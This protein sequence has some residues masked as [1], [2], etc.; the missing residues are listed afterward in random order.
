[1]KEKHTDT[2]VLLKEKCDVNWTPRSCDLIPFDFFRCG[3]VK[4][5]VYKNNPWTIQDLKAEIIRVIH[6]LQPQ[7]SKDVL[8]NY[9]KRVSTE[10]S[11]LSDI[12]FNH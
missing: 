9:D 2:I 8:L 11:H 12:L 3:Y 1:M 10:G 4:S 6:D 5:Q 7:L